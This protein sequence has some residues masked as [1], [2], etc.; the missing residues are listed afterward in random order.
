[1]RDSMSGEYINVP[2]VAHSEE[3]L[4]FAY[5]QR[6]GAKGGRSISDERAQEIW[7]SLEKLYPSDAPL[8]E[9]IGFAWRNGKKER[10]RV[11]ARAPF[12]ATFAAKSHLGD[13]RTSLWNEEDR[14]RPRDPSLRGSTVEQS[15]GND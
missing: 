9:F 14:L 8:R 10:V 13:V 15:G 2:S 4:Q 12:E 7:A 6:I 3:V 1:M 5:E 11:L